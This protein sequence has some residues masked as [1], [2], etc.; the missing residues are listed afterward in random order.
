MVDDTPINVEIA[1]SILEDEFDTDSACSGQ[2]ALLK[3][4]ESDYHL[5]LMDC[6]MPEM[7]GYDTTRAIRL[8]QTQNNKPD[9]PIIALTASALSETKLKCSEAGMDDFVSKPFDTNK[10]INLIKQ[11]L[12][13]SL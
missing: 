10:L 11:K 1:C 2:E 5:I 9:T 4:K 3:I 7:D 12:L 8:W 6:L 13:T